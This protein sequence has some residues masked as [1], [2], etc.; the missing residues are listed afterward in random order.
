MTPLDTGWPATPARGQSWPPEKVA[1]LCRGYLAGS[2]LPQMA[3]EIGCS[4][5][6]AVGKFWRLRKEGHSL[7]KIAA[8]GREPGTREQVAAWM[9][10]HGGSIADCSRALG[11]SYDATRSAW[12]RVRRK[13]GAQAR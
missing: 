9:A 11:F 7:A 8:A 12:C 10:S 6:A 2:T 1:R 3:R 13:L 5:S 4:K